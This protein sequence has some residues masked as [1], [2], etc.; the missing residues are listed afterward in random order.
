MKTILVLSVGGSAEPIVNAIK[1]NHPD[2]VY[3][4]CTCG[5][6]GSEKTIDSPGE[7]CGNK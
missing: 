5:P 2:F 4:F 7:P 1:N 3:F 6:K